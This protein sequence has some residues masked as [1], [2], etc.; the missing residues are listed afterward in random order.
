MKLAA[1]GDK[2]EQPAV[3]DH[4]FEKL[5]IIVHTALDLARQQFIDAHAKF[6]FHQVI[7]Q[8]RHALVHSV[9][10]DFEAIN[11][12]HW[13]HDIAKDAACVAVYGHDLQLLHVL[14]DLLPCR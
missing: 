2:V 14:R 13:S 12:L 5:G 6:R 1:T 4:T 3:V 8:E 11:A 10:V 7:Q 9:F